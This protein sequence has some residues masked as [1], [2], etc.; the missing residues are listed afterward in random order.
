MASTCAA[1]SVLILALVVV[2]A[3]AEYYVPPQ[4][5]VPKPVTKPPTSSTSPVQT[6]CVPKPN[7]DIAIQGFIFCKSGYETYPI[8]G[9]KVKVVCP[10]VDSYGKLIAKITLSSYPT[11]LKG[12]FYFITY[13]LS[14]KLKNINGCN[15]K[16]ES[17][18]VSSCKTPT[19]VNKGFTG[20]PLSTDKSKFLSDDN[21]NLY[22]FEPFYFSSP[23]APKRPVH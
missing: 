11:D 23:V 1:P 17:S 8:Q 16:L 7:P 13:G 22:T 21:L 2:V 20:A 15:V 9:A 19:N 5:D 12:Y 10:I 14:H 4:P 3:T 6:P 18:P